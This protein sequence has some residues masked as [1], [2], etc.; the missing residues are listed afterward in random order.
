MNSKKSPILLT[1]GRL[2]ASNRFAK[3]NIGIIVSEHIAGH[4]R[5][6]KVLA[7]GKHSGTRSGHLLVQRTIGVEDRFD[8]IQF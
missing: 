7:D 1:D 3:E 8:V 2:K 5:V 6:L 4:C